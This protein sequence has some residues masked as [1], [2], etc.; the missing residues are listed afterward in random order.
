MKR[1][2]DGP[3]TLLLWPPGPMLYD[4][5]CYHYCSF[6][7]IAGYLDLLTPWK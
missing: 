2:P 3:R 7:E 6:G 4:N 5:L 1:T